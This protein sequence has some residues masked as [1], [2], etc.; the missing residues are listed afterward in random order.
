MR[1]L[2]HLADVEARLHDGAHGGN[3]DREVLW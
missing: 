3:D 2:L 1:G